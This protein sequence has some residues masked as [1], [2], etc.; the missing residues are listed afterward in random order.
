MSDCKCVFFADDDRD[1]LE[2]LKE[3]CDS[4]GH[5]CHTFYGG[6]EL[7][8]AIKAESKKPDMV[9][10]DI[11]MPKVDGYQVISAIRSL[12]EFANLPIIIHS[13]RCDDVSIEKCFGLG[14]SLIVRKMSSFN[15]VKI[16]L[17]HLIN[18]DWKL[19]QPMRDNFV[20]GS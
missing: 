19:H 6:V 16:C 18:K 10:L 8:E 5:D 1:D 9:F 20:Y 14:A 12:D 2:I 13:G 3:I 11:E 7:V 17:E 15:E 4:L